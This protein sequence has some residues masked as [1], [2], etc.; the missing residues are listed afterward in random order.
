MIKV[1]MLYHSGGDV[2]A[3][4]FNLFADV[5]EKSITGPSANDHDC[6]NMYVIEIHCHCCSTTD[7]VCFPMSF[8]VNLNL[9]SPNNAAAPRKTCLT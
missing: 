5:A 6:V 9:S 3:E 2:V 8:I 4:L 7:R 1:L